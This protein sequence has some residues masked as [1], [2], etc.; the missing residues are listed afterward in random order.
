[1][2]RQQFYEPQVQQEASAVRGVQV[3]ITGTYVLLDDII[4]VLKEYADANG[5]PTVADAAE[6]LRGG[7]ESQEVTQV[8]QGEKVDRIEVYPDDP[9][10]LKPRWM[11]RACDAEG[12]IL[13]TTAGSFDQE[14]V[15]REAQERWP[16]APVM[17]VNDAS[18]DTVWEENDPGG[19]R[20]PSTKRR[21]PS[22]KRLWG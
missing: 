18:V 13:Y 3:T 19:I 5:Q 9:E 12:T 14:Y 7:A 20:S 10:S 6:W 8:D 15:I 11:S 17:L 2:A 21:R 16:Q 4:T 22:P 1:M